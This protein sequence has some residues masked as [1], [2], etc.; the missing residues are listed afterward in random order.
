[1]ISYPRKCQ[2]CDYVSNNPSMFFYHNQT[3]LPVPPGTQCHFGCGN[4]ATYRN[5]G[6][7]FTCTEQWQK[8]PTY[9]D[10]LS[11][12]TKKS[13]IGADARKE[14]TKKIFEE[15]VVFDKDTRNKNIQVLK[16]KSKITLQNSKNY[17]SYARKSRV[18]AQQWAKRNGYKI[19][20][21]TYHVDHKLSLVDCYNFGISIAD[22]SHPANLQVIPATVNSSKGGN[23]IITVEYLIGKIYANN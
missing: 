16:L 2:K 21:Q 9:L 12:R 17:R 6:G 13:W 1:M 14:K 3:H 20:Q 4:M 18:I 23:S 10:K 8:C 7:K 19:G 15:R 22:A 5:T 11:K